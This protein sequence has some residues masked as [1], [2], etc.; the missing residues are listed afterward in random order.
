MRLLGRGQ[1]LHFYSWPDV[2]AGIRKAN[3]SEPDNFK[4]GVKH[5]L[6]WAMQE[7]C[8]DV[9]SRLCFLAIQS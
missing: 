3:A 8:A 7:S 2:E 1:S 9:R 6:I 5:I 4:I